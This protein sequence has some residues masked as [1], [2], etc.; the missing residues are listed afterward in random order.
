[1]VLFADRIHEANHMHFSSG[2]L[3]NSS[4]L[5]SRTVCVH[6]CSASKHFA[7]GGSDLWAWWAWSNARALL[8]VTPGIRTGQRIGQNR[9]W[10]D[11]GVGRSRWCH[12]VPGNLSLSVSVSVYICCALTFTS[13][14]VWLTQL[15][16]FHL[17]CRRSPLST[18]VFYKT[19]QSPICC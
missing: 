5:P 16:A 6:L 14:H 19:P 11:G 18:A 13:S 15:S 9:W 7:A 3:K 2:E 10:G 4:A 1:M 12:W 8:L 17:L